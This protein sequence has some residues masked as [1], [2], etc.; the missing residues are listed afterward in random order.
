MHIS[1]GTITSKDFVDKSFIGY[2]YADYKIVLADEPKSFMKVKEWLAQKK[3]NPYTGKQFISPG[4]FTME[5]D[6]SEVESRYAAKQI[7]PNFYG[8][9]NVEKLK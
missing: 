4:V 8:V 9:V 3:Q 2:S 5:S 6:T 7:N 1:A